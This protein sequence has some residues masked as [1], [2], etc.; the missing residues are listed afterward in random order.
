MERTGEPALGSAV[1]RWRL[2]QAKPLA[3][4][5][6]SA[7]TVMTVQMRLTIWG[8]WVAAIPPFA[9]PATRSFRHASSS[10]V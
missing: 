9:A 6:P 7:A 2:S 10:A 1:L 5:S 4:T 8:A 3:R